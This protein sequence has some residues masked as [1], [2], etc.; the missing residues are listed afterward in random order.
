MH[1][2]KQW[3][4][5]TE[6]FAN[7]QQSK[8]IIPTDNIA[9]D[10]LKVMRQLESSS[11]M[12]RVKKKLLNPQRSRQKPLLDGNIKIVICLYRWHVESNI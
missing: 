7:S 10:E 4:E 3:C 6:C 5:N 12:N 8:F 2:P 1:Q 11:T 9:Y